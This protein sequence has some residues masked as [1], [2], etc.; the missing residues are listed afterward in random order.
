MTFRP[1]GYTKGQYVLADLEPQAVLYKPTLNGVTVFDTRGYCPNFLYLT[2]KEEDLGFIS[3]LFTVTHP[4]PKKLYRIQRG[5]VYSDFKNQVVIEDKLAR[6]LTAPVV[7]AHF[8]YVNKDI[9]ILPFVCRPEDDHLAFNP[10]EGETLLAYIKR[11]YKRAGISIKIDP[12]K[13]TVFVKPAENSTLNDRLTKSTTNRSLGSTLEDFDIPTDNLFFLHK[14]YHFDSVYQNGAICDQGDCEREGFNVETGVY[15][16]NL[17]IRPQK[18]VNEMPGVYFSQLRDFKPMALDTRFSLWNDTNPYGDIGIVYSVANIVSQFRVN[19]R[20]IHR[21]GY[22]PEVAPRDFFGVKKYQGIYNE[23]EAIA[24]TNK[25]S[26]SEALYITVDFTHS[27]IL[28]LGKHLKGD[29]TLAD[30]IEL[31]QKERQNHWYIHKS[32]LLKVVDLY[33]NDDEPLPLIV[34]FDASSRGNV[35]ERKTLG[36]EFDTDSDHELLV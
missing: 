5:N 17:K 14:T 32:S 1:P 29:Y 36:T 26:L 19:F 31:Y 16:K 10:E 8:K 12:K 21:F 25:I 9:Q 23:K 24:R 18:Q 34:G 27:E 30:V 22:G 28:F 11:S 15:D 20:G 4:V 2:G 33:E 7:K 13:P 35:I 3:D 6:S